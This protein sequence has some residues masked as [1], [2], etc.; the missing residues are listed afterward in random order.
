MLSA[1]MRGR[2]RHDSRYDVLWV[3]CARLI[4]MVGLYNMIAM[5]TRSV[6]TDAENAEKFPNF[7]TIPA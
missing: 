4:A 3:Y 1:L 2:Q 6:E 7:T 5:L